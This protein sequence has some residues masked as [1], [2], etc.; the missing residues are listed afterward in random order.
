MK[1]T[2]V[3]IV[4]IILAYIIVGAIVYLCIV[5][6]NRNIYDPIEVAHPFNQKFVTSEYDQLKDL[7]KS[8][9]TLLIAV[10]VASI[11][12]SEKIVNYNSSTGLPKVLLVACWILLLFSVVLTGTGLTYI[13][14]GYHQALNFPHV[15]IMDLCTRGLACFGFSGLFFGIALANMLVAGILTFL[16]TK[17]LKTA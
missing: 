13:T 9:L 1:K 5:S 7:A 3:S 10:F 11:T 16:N 4:L 14:A 2:I 8:F 17:N 6:F 15:K 12:F